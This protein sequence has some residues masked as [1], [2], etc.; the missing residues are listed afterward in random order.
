LRN[1]LWPIAIHVREKRPIGNAWAAQYPTREKLLN[2]FDRYKGAGVGVALGPAAGVVDFEVDDQAGAAELLGRIELPRTVSWQSTRGVHRLFLWDKR[3]EGLP[4]VA[5][6]VGAELRIGQEG[7]QLVSV[8]PPSVGDDRR[9]RRWLGDCWEIAPFPASLL[10]ELEKPKVTPRPVVLPTG[11]DRY[12]EAAL[13]YEVRCVATA[14]E[15]TRNSTLNRAAYA[16]G[17]LVAVGLLG[18]QTVEDALAE[19]AHA[20]GLGEGE[21]AATLK[22]GLDA[23]VK[24]P[25]KV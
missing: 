10:K 25:R 12:A 3:L 19:A 15:G 6:V 2:V 23:G 21:V 13:R 17:G 18:R 16:L 8:T 5:H 20:A 9:R 14:K 7:K 11:G 4:T 22:S 1:G 24:R